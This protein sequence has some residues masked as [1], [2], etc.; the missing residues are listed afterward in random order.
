MKQ[1][2]EVGLKGC[3]RLRIREGSDG[4]VVGDTGWMNNLV[5]NDGIDKF[6][7]RCF[8]GSSG[9]LQVSHLSIGTG[10]A[11][12]SAQTSLTGE[13]VEANERAAVSLSF[14]Q[15]AASNG[16]ATMQF[17]ATLASADSFITAAV[18][19]SNIGLFNSILNGTMMAGNTYTSSA[20]AT[21]QNVEMS[22]QIRIN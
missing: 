12:T 10:G 9:S 11:P 19:I 3:F 7:A 22:Y 6:F 1:A 8:A 14:S 20:L 13:I 16:T 2:D 18:N 5:T 15:R 4:K 17:A 21:N